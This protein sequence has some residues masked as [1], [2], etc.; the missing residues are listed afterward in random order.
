MQYS[1]MSKADLLAKKQEL[2]KTFAELKE[3]NLK[4]D[5]SR[6]KPGADQLA[7]SMDMLT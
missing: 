4:L 3:M 5:M 7:L 2:D 6:G 1:Q